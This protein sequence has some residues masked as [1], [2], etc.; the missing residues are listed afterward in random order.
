MNVYV[1]V[2]VCVHTRAHSHRQACICI[3]LL[4]T[5]NPFGFSVWLLSWDR[6]VVSRQHI[7]DLGCEILFCTLSTKGEREINWHEAISKVDLV[8]LH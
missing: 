1:C 3:Y 7:Y 2:W 8:T 5:L 6:A 4:W